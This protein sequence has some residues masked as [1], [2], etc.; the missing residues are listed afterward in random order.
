LLQLE[1]S[2]HSLSV[3]KSDQLALKMTFSYGGKSRTKISI[4]GV[5][6]EMVDKP[7]LRQGKMP[8]SLADRSLEEMTALRKLLVRKIDIRLMPVLIVLFLLKY[9]LSDLP[10]CPHEC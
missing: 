4:E 1:A 8:D 9:V 10:G 6:D 3:S 2:P 7:E 5:T